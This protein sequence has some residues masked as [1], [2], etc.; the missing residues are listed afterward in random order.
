MIS[1]CQ[2]N[3]LNPGCLRIRCSGANSISFR[4]FSLSMIDL[5]YFG[6]E[7][8]CTCVIRKGLRR[9]FVHIIGI[10][11]GLAAFGCE[12]LNEIDPVRSTSPRVVPPCQHFR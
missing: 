11:N 6:P 8:T 9:A 12:E 1:S 2:W 5:A 4:P 3:T 7:V 10:G